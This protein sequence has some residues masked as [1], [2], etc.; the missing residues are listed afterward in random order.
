MEYE[1][2]STAPLVPDAFAA[3]AVYFANAQRLHEVLVDTFRRIAEARCLANVD[4]FSEISSHLVAM[5]AISGADAALAAWPSLMQ[6][7]LKRQARLQQCNLDICS[8]ALQTTTALLTANASAAP[9]GAAGSDR[10]ATEL[11]SD[12]RVKATVISFPDRRAAAAV[13]GT[14]ASIQQ[15]TR[16]K[17]Q[18]AVARR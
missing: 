12:R 4:A 9:F 13:Q 2:Q 1:P 15:S 7:T 16:H 11:I 14:E 3:W 5:T 6:S 10:S 18:A 8:S 17:G